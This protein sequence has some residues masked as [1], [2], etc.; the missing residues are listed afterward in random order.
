LNGEFVAL[1][2]EFLTGSEPYFATTIS[3]ALD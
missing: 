2:G 1:N 3:E